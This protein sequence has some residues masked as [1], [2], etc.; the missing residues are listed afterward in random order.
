MFKIFEV[1]GGKVSFLP[2][3]DPKHIKGFFIS[4]IILLIVVGLAGWLKIDEKD[5]WKF[6]N[7]LIQQFGLKYQV[8]E[9]DKKEELDGRVE[10]EIDRAIERVRPE[11]DRIILEA[12]RIYK[13]RYVEEENDES[14]CYTDECKKLAP[15]MR[16]CASWVE[17]CTKN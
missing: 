6:Y 12:D 10:L 4:S 3:L 8:P 9:V 17:D 16:I 14:I 13:P 7:L 11:Y 15:P 1:K 5:V 2:S